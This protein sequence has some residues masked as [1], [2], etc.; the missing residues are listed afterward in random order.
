MDTQRRMRYCCRLGR[1]FVCPVSTVKWILR[2]SDSPRTRWC[3]PRTSA[4]PRRRHVATA[5]AVAGV[6]LSSYVSDYLYVYLYRYLP[7][8]V[9]LSISSNLCQ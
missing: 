2:A 6:C 1:R 4:A 9:Y 7:I 3:S 8:C 5:A